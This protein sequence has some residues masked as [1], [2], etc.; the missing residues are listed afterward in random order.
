M[1]EGLGSGM[2]FPQ[3][4]S[5]LKPTTWHGSK[6]LLSTLQFIATS[7]CRKNAENL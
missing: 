4:P 1:F 3:T 2:F 6:I 5:Q 7:I